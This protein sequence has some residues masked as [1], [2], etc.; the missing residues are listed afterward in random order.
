LEAADEGESA[1]RVWGLGRGCGYRYSGSRLLIYLLEVLERELL[2]AGVEDV[3]EVLHPH[4]RR[5]SWRSPEPEK[6][7]SP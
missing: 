4:R 1:A 7:R 6:T 3:P 5:C 2:L